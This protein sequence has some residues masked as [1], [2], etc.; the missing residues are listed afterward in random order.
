MEGVNGA[1]TERPHLEPE[2][3]CMAACTP[4]KAL[5]R[6]CL[7]GEETLDGCTHRVPGHHAAQVG[8]H[9]VDGKALDFVAVGHHQVGGIA[10]WGQGCRRAQTCELAV[11][12]QLA[13]SESMA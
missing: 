7:C 8:A 3:A 10:L 6:R 9:R 4:C 13:G 5:N 2:N 12:R 1:K 11:G